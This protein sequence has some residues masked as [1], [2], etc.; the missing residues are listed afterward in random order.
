MVGYA[1]PEERSRRWCGS[2]VCAR[3][4]GKCERDGKKGSKPGRMAGAPTGYTGATVKRGGRG[5]SGGE[6]RDGDGGVVT[7]QR[8]R[9]RRRASSRCGRREREEREGGG[10]SPGDQWTQPRGALHSLGYYVV[11]PPLRSNTMPAATYYAR[12]Y[13]T[14]RSFVRPAHLPGHPFAPGV[15]LSSSLS[16]L[17]PPLLADCALSPLAFVLPLYPRTTSSSLVDPSSS[18][19]HDEYRW[20]P[21]LTSI[22][23]WRRGVG[24]RARENS[25]LH[26]Y[27]HRR[28]YSP[29]SSY[30]S[31]PPP[32]LPRPLRSW[33]RGRRVSD[34]HPR[35]GGRTRG[36]R[37]LS[38]D[39]NSVSSIFA[40]GCRVIGLSDYP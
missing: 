9:R 28:D 23:Q 26:A 25:S 16:P 8:R 20:P 3:D 10:G 17:P 7:R 1:S 4:A 21:A 18:A 30:A 13:Y 27:T 5:R 15:P 31:P 39:E 14:G 22:R 29:S 33:I 19:R 6:E 37:P 36:R 34:T 35:G 11:S 38:G 24:C 2:P 40:G 12:R 32:L